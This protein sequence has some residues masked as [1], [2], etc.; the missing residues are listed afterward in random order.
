[1]MLARFVD[2]VCAASVNQKSPTDLSEFVRPAPEPDA[3][4][5]YECPE[6]VAN[7]ALH[8]STRSAG[9]EAPEP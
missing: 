5:V 6:A 4:Y 9:N 1:M 2:A 8:A 7:G 3:A